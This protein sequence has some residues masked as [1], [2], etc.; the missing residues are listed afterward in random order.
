MAIGSQLRGSFDGAGEGAAEG[1]RLRPELTSGFY[2]RYRRNG[3]A[4]PVLIIRQVVFQDRTIAPLV[5]QIFPF[6]RRELGIPNTLLASKKLSRVGTG[7][8][9]PP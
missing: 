5:P 8:A 2:T 7:T 9:P 3:A 1:S 6:P 4:A